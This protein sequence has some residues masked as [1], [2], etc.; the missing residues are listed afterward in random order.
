MTFTYLKKLS[1]GEN[2]HDAELE[3]LETALK[4]H[5]GIG[6]GELEIVKGEHGKPCFAQG[7]PHFNFSNSR[8][9]A[10]CAVS[11]VPV[12][13]DIEVERE[14]SDAVMNRF[15]GGARGSKRERTAI[16]T[17]YESMGKCTGEG[18]PHKLC[19]E[20]FVFTE[21]FVGDVSICVCT[22]SEKSQIFL[23]KT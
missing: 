1:D 18:I 20:D 11:D 22:K 4:E 13:V 9:Y 15:L 5:F 6:P 12:G 10:A 16:W 17:R 19:K 3:M 2:A 23:S 21:A 7:Y 8:E 14:V